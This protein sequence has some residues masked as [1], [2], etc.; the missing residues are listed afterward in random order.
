MVKV[1][2]CWAPC[3]WNDNL[4]TGCKAISFYSVALSVVLMTF[5]IFNMSGGD[6]TQ[7]YNPLFESDIRMS[8]Q[9]VGGCMILYFLCLILS[10]ILMVYGL[11]IM[12]RGLMMPWMGLFGI[13]IL[14]QLIFGL[15]LLGGYYI[16]IDCVLYTLIIWCWM[17]YNMYCWLVVYS[18]Y[19]V[20][21][22][23]QSPNIELLYP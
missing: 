5:V 14:F 15:W 19:L 8:M 21:A 4:K 9:V 2:A 13:G 23:M 12:I 3:I 6:S 7:L 11:H 1:D 16:Y 20:Y 10:S 18:Q 17:A 22:A